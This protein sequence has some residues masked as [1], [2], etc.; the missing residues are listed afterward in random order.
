M[1]SFQ[2][3][4]GL[5]LYVTVNGLS[6]VTSADVS[7]SVFIVDLR[8]GDVKKVYGTSGLVIIAVQSTFPSE[9]MTFQLS[10]FFSAATV[11]VPPCCSWSA[12]TEL[13]VFGLVAQ[14]A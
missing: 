1:P 9:E 5:I 8:S 14:S 13:Q 7:R 6:L 4:S 12:G 11:T 3:A 2:T 10:M